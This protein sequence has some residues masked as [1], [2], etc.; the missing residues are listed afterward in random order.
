MNIFNLDFTISEH[1][2]TARRESNTVVFTCPICGDV[3]QVEEVDDNTITKR[4]SDS[5]FRHG[6]AYALTE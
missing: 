2:C 6:G 1:I 4:L 3:R 5:P